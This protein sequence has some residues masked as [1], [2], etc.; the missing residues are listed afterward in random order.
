[1]P[2]CLWRDETGRIRVANCRL[3]LYF[4]IEAYHRGLRPEEMVEHYDRLRLADA[5]ATIAYYLDHREEV[6]EY[7]T[8]LNRRADEL[9]R[10]IESQPGYAERRAELLRRK[11]VM[12]A[13]RVSLPQ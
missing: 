2:A 7:L 9:R 5:Y 4:L 3:P 11:A 13:N 12:E 8:E 1:M 6:D 10:E